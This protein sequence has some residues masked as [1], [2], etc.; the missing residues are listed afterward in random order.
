M[1]ALIWVSHHETAHRR[2]HRYIPVY[3]AS[4]KRLCCESW[5]ANSI[6]NICKPA[7]FMKAARSN[8]A[9]LVV[10]DARTPIERP[11]R[12]ELIQS[13]I[14]HWHDSVPLTATAG[15]LI[16]WRLSKACFVFRRTDAAAQLPSLRSLRVRFGIVPES[17]GNTNISM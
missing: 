16:H 1:S 17:L 8:A 4:E 9:P 7:R 3:Q 2:G 14:F 12:T 6:S 5:R 11:D 13:G 15:Q 10:I